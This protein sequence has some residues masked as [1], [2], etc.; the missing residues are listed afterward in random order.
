MQLLSSHPALAVCWF[1][2][3][4]LSGMLEP[5]AIKQ[6]KILDVACFLG[7]A[8]EFRG[9]CEQDH[10]FPM[11]RQAPLT[12]PTPSWDVSLVGTTLS[13][14]NMMMASKWIGPL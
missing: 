12:Q 3:A 2:K 14:C 5:R 9:R 6:T 4:K 8:T 7:F 10:V 13:H 11:L 1:R